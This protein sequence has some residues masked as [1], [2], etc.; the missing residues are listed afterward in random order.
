[1]K[2]NNYT[3]Y[4]FIGIGGIGMSALARYFKLGGKQVL[5]YDK[6]ET[7]LTKQLQNE[8]ISVN[9]YD[10][11]STIPSAISTE[12]TLVI[13]TPA[14]PKDSKI[15]NYFSNN[16]FEVIKRSKALGELT[17]NTFSIC[18]AGTHGKTTTTTLIG[19]ICKTANLKST[20]FLGGISENYQTNFIFNGNEISIIEADEFDRS[21]LTLSP[22]F[23]CITSTDADHLDIYGKKESLLQSFNDFA[24]LVPE[25][26]KLFIKKGLQIAAKH[27]TYSVDEKADYFADNIQINPDFSTFDFNYSEGKI[28]GIKTF[29]QGKHNIENATVAL[30][31]GKEMNI[32]DEILK[33]SIETFKG[34]KRRF[35]RNI[36][37]NGKVYIDDYAH[38]PTELNAALNAVRS[39][40][41]NRKL[42]T[43]FQPHLFSRTKD[44]ADD[45]AKSLENTDA[46]ILLDIYPAREL[47]IEGV[48]SNWLESKI[49]V[50]NKKVCS[51]SQAVDE[52]LKQDFDVLL[53]VGAGDIDTLYEPLCDKIKE[54]K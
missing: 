19:H 27:K 49:N 24:N 26:G 35:T 54:L 13:F 11:I 46:L 42:L 18:I 43:I 32:S 25:S 41:P 1:M 17:K 12:N 16:G 52:I 21:F 9:Y 50:E 39:L 3:Y 6:T 10:E 48:T 8:G 14:I 34:I 36:F 22:D 4:Y 45:F 28:I 40:Y 38:H 5:G 29:L 20:A 15:L 31:I 7:K 30:A 33:K 2:I 53:T 47:P 23:A 37:E 44:F 51:L